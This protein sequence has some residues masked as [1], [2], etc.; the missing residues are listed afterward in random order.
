MQNV[1]HTP[2]TTISDTFSDHN[3]VATIYIVGPLSVLFLLRIYRTLRCAQLASSQ[4]TKKFVCVL[5]IISQYSVFVV[6][7]FDAIKGT[8]HAVA[9]FLTFFLLLVYHYYTHKPNKSLRIVDGRFPLKFVLGFI[10][11]MCIL[12]FAGLVSF[13]DE[14]LQHTGLWAIATLLEILGVL[15][16][17]ALDMVDINELGSRL[18]VAYDMDSV[19]GSD[20]THALGYSMHTNHALQY[21]K[22]TSTQNMLYANP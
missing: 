20:D 5:L 8:A 1:Q 3:V 10:S 22:L 14:P 6:I 9:T 2:T 7:R 17:G 21:H 4:Q 13:V 15:F 12:C 11:T 18:T 19:C 16:L